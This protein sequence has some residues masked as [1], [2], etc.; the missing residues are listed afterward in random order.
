MLVQIHYGIITTVVIMN[1]YTQLYAWIRHSFNNQ[2][3]NIDEFR[4]VFP[5]S[6]TPKVIHDLLKDG[7][8][9]RIER[10]T[11]KVIGPMQLIENIIQKDK[12]IKDVIKEAERK[13]A[14]SHSTAVTIWT[15][16]YYWADFTKG[17]KPIH[18]KVLKEDLPYWE[19]FFTQRKARYSLPDEN[20]T[21]FGST[22]ILHPAEDCEAV[23]KED[24][25]VIPLKEVVKFCLQ[26]EMTYQPA[27]EYLDEKYEIGYKKRAALR[28]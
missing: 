4:S 10:G 14:H 3:F 22:Y 19:D 13:Y 24:R 6:Q 16:G 17:F 27:L 7:Y 23:K 5:T 21:L 26:R 9:K 18:I 25:I 12:E 20:K 2:A 1:K 11:Y 8:I 28:T 15:S